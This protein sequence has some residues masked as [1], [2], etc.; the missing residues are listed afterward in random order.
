MIHF[1]PT[2]F[3]LMPLP[4]LSLLLF[5]RIVFLSL[6]P[7]SALLGPVLAQRLRK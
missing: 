4:A 1:V 5:P 3:L 6:P 2:G 7:L